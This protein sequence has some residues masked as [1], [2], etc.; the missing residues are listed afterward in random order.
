MNIAPVEKPSFAD[1]NTSA[2]F[3]RKD[4]LCKRLLRRFRQRFSSL[5]LTWETSKTFLVYT[6]G[7]AKKRNALCS[8]E[9]HG[10]LWTTCN[11]L[12]EKG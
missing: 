11:E 5:R 10:I 3:A 9:T 2:M 1:G 4:L 8:R 12:G 7:A 6:C